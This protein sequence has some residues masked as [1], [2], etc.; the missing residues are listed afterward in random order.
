MYPVIT[1]V[2]SKE[3]QIE[4]MIS[5]IPSLLLFDILGEGGVVLTLAMTRQGRARFYAMDAADFVFNCL[6]MDGRTVCC[7]S[8]CSAW[9]FICD[10]PW[11]YYLIHYRLQQNI[12]HIIT[13]K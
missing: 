4:S 11:D 13:Q 3:E 7:S 6:V 9:L 8:D 5:S 12:V 10:I 2:Q 1:S